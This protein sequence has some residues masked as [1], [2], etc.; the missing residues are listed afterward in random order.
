MALAYLITDGILGGGT[1]EL[2]HQI[3]TGTYSQNF[4]LQCDFEPKL[5][6][7]IVG[8]GYSTEYSAGKGFLYDLDTDTV[9]DNGISNATRITLTKSGNNIR[10]QTSIANWNGQTYHVWAFGAE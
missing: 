7:I 8:S 4:T 1:G 3:F 9:L 5:V 6:S 10:I 2:K